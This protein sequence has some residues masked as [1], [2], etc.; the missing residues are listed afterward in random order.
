MKDLTNQIRNLNIIKGQLCYE[1]S[2][3]RQALKSAHIYYSITFINT[4]VKQGILDKRSDKYYF[5]D[6]KPIHISKLAAAYSDYTNKIKEYNHKC[7][8]HKLQNDSKHKIEEAIQL[9][10]KNGFIVY[11]PASKTINL[12]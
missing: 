9:L 12:F 3:L 8:Y 5:T 6:K 1:L 2:S 11:V 7:K 4:L 10:E